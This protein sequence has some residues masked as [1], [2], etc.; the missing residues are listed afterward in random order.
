MNDL[1]CTGLRQLLDE[2]V[3]GEL[4][5]DAE[6]RVCAHLA[7][8][9]ACRICAE[10][11]KHL[12]E[13]V[14]RCGAGCASPERGEELVRL[15]PTEPR[16]MTVTTADAGVLRKPVRRGARRAAAVVVV[17]VGLIGFVLMQTRSAPRSLVH[18]EM[19]R[20]VLAD[21]LAHRSD[22]HAMSYADAERH[23]RAQGVLTTLP[24]FDPQRVSFQGLREIQLVGWCAS[25]QLCF[26][27]SDGHAFS[28]FTTGAPVVMEGSDPG[29]KLPAGC[30]LCAQKGAHSVLCFPFENVRCW[31]VTDRD[32][33]PFYADVVAQAVYR[34]R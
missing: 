4:S 8:C 2:W 32:P 26:E 24:A 10:E 21:H 13:L 7:G 18:A 14:R 25:V 5:R 27:T 31:I 17:G 9:E 34:S 3:D 29:R 20:A 15:G 23:L 22:L 28:L 16:G 1:D 12:K 6:V 11:R 30:C 33:E 19:A